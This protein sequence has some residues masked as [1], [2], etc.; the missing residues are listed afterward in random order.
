MQA[1]QDLSKQYT[2]MKPL[3]SEKR[4]MRYEEWKAQLGENTKFGV[5][6]LVYHH[7]PG[8]SHST[9]AGPSVDLLGRSA[10]KTAAAMQFHKSEAIQNLTNWISILFAAIDPPMWCRKK[11]VYQLAATEFPLLQ[12]CDLKHI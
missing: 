3:E 5:I 12:E 9:P 10:Q 1:F 6:Q 8:Q 7:Q 11:A 2:P 4:S